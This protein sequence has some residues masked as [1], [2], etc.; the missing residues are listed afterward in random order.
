IDPKNPITV[1]NPKTFKLNVK[2]PNSL[3]LVSLAGGDYFQVILDSTEAKKHATASDP[4]AK[5][6][7]TSHSA[8]FGAYNVTSFTPASELRETVNPN[9]WG[10]AKISNVI[11]R[12]VPDPGNRL[13]LIK[14]GQVNYVDYLAFDQA[15]SL[16][17]AQN[18]Q[19]V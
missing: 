14:T 9:F 15:R 16:L 3:T 18:L 12:V 7:M 6:W 17:G 10:K 4:W 11:L 8:S 2:T 13:Q 1:I 5:D 19:V